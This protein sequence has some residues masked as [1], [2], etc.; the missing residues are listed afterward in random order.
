MDVG[1]EIVIGDGDTERLDRTDT[2]RG[3]RWV[4]RNALGL[5]CDL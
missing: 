5:V 1:G 4:G 2:M 3:R